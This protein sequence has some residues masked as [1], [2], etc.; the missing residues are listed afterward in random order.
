ME[1]WRVADW[2]K[3]WARFSSI[4]W[5]RRAGII[6]LVRRIESNTNLL[7]DED[8]GP[9]HARLLL[10]WIIWKQKQNLEITFL[11]NTASVLG[12]RRIVT[13]KRSQML[14]KCANWTWQNSTNVERNTLTVTTIQR[15]V[16]SWNW[17]VFM[18]GCLN[19][20]TTLT[21]FLKTCQKT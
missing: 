4:A 13:S 3:P 7:L 9:F 16:Y 18:A 12:I 21:T 11:Q 10:T 1:A 17:T 6:N 8:F 14:V 19:I 2:N 5:W 15:L 20:I